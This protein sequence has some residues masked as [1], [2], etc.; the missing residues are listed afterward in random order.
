[1]RGL[2]WRSVVV[3]M[4]LTSLA[5]QGAVELA[6]GGAAVAEIVVAEGAA[7]AVAYAAEEMQ[8]WVEAISGAK[9]PIVKQRSQAATAA[10][11]LAVKPEDASFA[12][13][14]ARIG[15][16]DGYAARTRG[17]EVH[18]VATCPKGVLNG[19]YRLLRR[20]SDIIW[21]RPNAD[22]GTVYTRKPDFS[23]ASTDY[24]DV[25]V[26][27]QRGWQMHAG[28]N[29][30][31]YEWLFRQCTNRSA[32]HGR[33]SPENAR[34]GMIASCVP[35]HNLT[36]VY[37]TGDKY[38]D[39]HPEFFPLVKGERLDP[40]KNRLRTQL[41]FTNENL[42]EV[43]WQELDALIQANIEYDSYGVHIE[44]VWPTC[45]CPSC[46]VPITLPNGDVLKPEDDNF[47]STQYFSWLNGLAA[48][49]GQK[50]PG[51]MLSSFAYFFT[52]TAPGVAVE[53]NISISYAPIRKD[54]RGSILESRNAV[55]RANMSLWLAKTSA[56]SW[57]EYYGLYCAYPR[58]ID[59]VAM[60]DWRYLHATGGVER[61]F[62]ELWADMATARH[63]DGAAFWDFNAPY[64]WV[65]ANGVWNPYESVAAL[66]G[67]FFSRVYGAAAL[68]VAEFYRLT[69]R[70]WFALKGASLYNDASLPLWRRGIL[71]GGLEEACREALTRAAALVPEGNGAKMLA[72]LRTSFETQV[73]RAKVNMG[74]VLRAAKA[75]A[76]LPMD[77]D[78][79][80]PS[81]LTYPVREFFL[82]NGDRPKASTQVKMLH[83]QKNL[84]LGV[85]SF[86]ARPGEAFAKPSGQPRDVWPPGEKIE[87]FLTGKDS[88]KNDCYYQIVFDVNGNIY[89]ALGRDASWNGDFSLE[90]K[91][92]N[93]GHSAVLTVP[94]KTINLQSAAEKATL[95]IL[96]VRY[97]SHGEEN[98]EVSTLYNGRHHK[99]ETFT[100]IELR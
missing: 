33:V 43:F 81:W 77:P 14:L 56:I 25:P 64:L 49:V 29:S 37:I 78:F 2:G 9:L 72:A 61:T 22:F 30:E 52:E 84:Y 28:R 98:S 80:D 35:H 11:V 15:T 41:C 36:G 44:D 79:K 70:A 5:S 3:V 12:D 46:L 40:R 86:D 53:P 32:A 50:Y 19:V 74:G 89:D 20:N 47:R 91:T 7:P 54:S 1:M 39:A 13:D 73:E 4:A 92:T 62:S 16:T 59:A 63:P 94:F 76:P 93:D 31:Q 90:Q 24:V 45:E 6:R 58:P 95:E 51:K 82:K 67:E 26:Y 57:R 88:Q 34:Y 17:S 66:R 85:K 48:K 21:A 100:R 10:V 27:T 69:E 75:K 18:I 65:T 42:K 97:A 60:E 96:V 55:T 68:E 71:E 8:R 99:P 83:D 87:I 38:Y 23:L